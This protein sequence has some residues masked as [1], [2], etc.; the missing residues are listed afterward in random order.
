MVVTNCRGLQSD[1][2]F[3]IAK[4][5]DDFSS[6]SSNW[7]DKE[8]F[9][10]EP[11]Y[12]IW[13]FDNLLS[14]SFLASADK[15]FTNGKKIVEPVEYNP[16]LMKQRVRISQTDWSKEVF[17]VLLQIANVHPIEISPFFMLG[18]VTGQTEQAQQREHMDHGYVGEIKTQLSWDRFQFDPSGEKVI[19]TF[20]FIVYFNDVGGVVFPHVGKIV[21]AK[22][23]RIVMFQNYHNH[24]NKKVDYRALHYGTYRIE[25]KRLAVFGILTEMIP[26]PNMAK[27]LAVLYSPNGHCHQEPPSKRK[28]AWYKVKKLD[29]T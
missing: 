16:H 7:F 6:F 1:S 5:A 27:P 17:E 15:E 21:N 26:A 3:K 12:D 11:N 25:P 10:L 4:Q 2:E 28:F 22:R 13:V 23:G 24:V 18:D 29:N 19:P 20:S 9:R 14:E 8:P